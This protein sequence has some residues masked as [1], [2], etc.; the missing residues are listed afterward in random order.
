MAV[1]NVERRNPQ[2]LVAVPVSMEDSGQVAELLAKIS[3][4]RDGDASSI[5]YETQSQTGAQ[6]LP[7]G[8]WRIKFSRTDYPAQ[9]A[10]PGDWILVANATHSD[11]NGWQLRPESEVFVYGVSL[12]LAGTADDFTATFIEKAAP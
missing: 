1:I 12:G 9:F 11:Q 3:V 5:V 10:F 6:F 2:D 8:G 7:Q 4:P